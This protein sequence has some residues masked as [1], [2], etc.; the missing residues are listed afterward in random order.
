M[1][2]SDNLKSFS[3]QVEQG[4]KK[5]THSTA[6]VLLRGTTGFF[7]GLVLALIFQELFQY[8]FLVLSFLTILFLAIIYKVL[9]KYTLLQILVFDLICFLTL[10]LL[11]MYVIIAP[12]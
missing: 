2:L 10:T 1:G 8:G 7:L 4:A 12:N 3:Y 11:R 9:S 6:H 5:A